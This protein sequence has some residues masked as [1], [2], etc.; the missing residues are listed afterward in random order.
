M[1]AKNKKKEAAEEVVTEEVTTQ[2]VPTFTK[3]QFVTWGKMARYK[4]YLNAQLEDG[5]S[6]TK[7]EVFEL[8]EKAFKVKLNIK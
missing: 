6:Y 1:A 7:A 3:R 4:D 5:E 8:I 2:P